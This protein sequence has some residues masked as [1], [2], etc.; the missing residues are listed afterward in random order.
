MPDDGAI[1][2]HDAA[3]TSSPHAT[4]DQRTTEP[5]GPDALAE[6]LQRIA[7]ARE[8]FAHLLAAEIERFKLRLRK[9]AMWAIVGLTALVLLLALLVAATGVLLAGLAELI[10]SLL[11]GRLWLGAVLV[12]GGVLLIGVLALGWGLWAW[13]ASAFDAVRQRFAARKR[14]QQ[15][16]FGKSVDSA[17]DHHDDPKPDR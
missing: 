11:G 14:R 9:A 17:D 2:P 6:S 13:Q 12:G 7:E 10:G 4:D 8:Y 5:T 3:N 15:G 16:R 1:P